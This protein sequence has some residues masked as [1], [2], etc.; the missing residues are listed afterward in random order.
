MVSHSLQTLSII[1]SKSF[2]VSTTL[3]FP[4]QQDLEK[5]LAPSQAATPLI[6]LDRW[7]QLH[8]QESILH[9]VAAFHAF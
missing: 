5:I 2:A 4:V 8:H 9:R 1:A 7:S 6:V 3:A